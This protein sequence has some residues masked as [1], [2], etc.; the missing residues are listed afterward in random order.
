[1]HIRNLAP[2]LVLSLFIAF[3]SGAAAQ[4]TASVGL[5]EDAEA[6]SRHAISGEVSDTPAKPREKSPDNLFDT[7]DFLKPDSKAPKSTLKND[8]EAKVPVKISINVPHN[9]EALNTLTAYPYPVQPP[10]IRQAIQPLP[11]HYAAL[12]GKLIA[13]GYT[14][15][16]SKERAYPFGGWRWQYAYQAGLRRSNLG[17]PHVVTE[18]YAWADEMVKYV[19]PEVKRLNAAEINRIARYKT[20]QDDYAQNRVEVEADAI[21]KGLFPVDVRLQKFDNRQMRFGTLKLP[22]GSWWLVGTHKVPGLTYYW[23][24]PFDVDADQP[25]TM[26]LTEANALLIQGGW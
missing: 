24:L 18:M 23:N 7:S 16:T 14:Q 19:Q 2:V 20:I 12:K 13:S 25:K 1:M 17:V 10:R 22:P 4:K 8:S 11:D 21:R 3:A 5:S 15:R 26:E 9:M 6:A